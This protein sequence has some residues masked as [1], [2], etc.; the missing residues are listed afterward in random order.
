MNPSETKLR[1]LLL[2]PLPP[3]VG[4]IARWTQ[5]MT[6]S[7][8][9]NSEIAIQ[10]LDTR[11][12]PRFTRPLGLIQRFWQGI[13]GTPRLWLRLL[14]TLRVRKP[15]VVHITTSGSL[16]LMRDLVS[17][18]IIRAHHVPRILHIRYGRIPQLMETPTWET[19]LL[20]QAMGH[21]D[22]VLCLE[23]DTA[24]AISEC[25]PS[26]RVEVVPNFAPVPTL[27]SS[28]QGKQILYT[29]RIS[30]AKGIEDLI[31]AW[32]AVSAPEW[33]LALAGPLSPE[34]RERV[35]ESPNVRML[36]I[37]TPLEIGEALDRSAIYVLPSHTEGF[38]NGLLE[39][40]MHGLACISTSVGAVPHMLSEDAGIV[41]PPRS[42][43]ELSRA[44]AALQADPQLRDRLGDNA[45]QRAITLY[46]DA[47]VTKQYARIWHSLIP[48]RVQ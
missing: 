21:A 6:K 32:E 11:L 19:W 34:L 26:L 39:A 9:L 28:L 12:W 36:G 43:Q 4:G 1:V 2:S 44:L 41:V 25:N 20:C 5:L 8:H 13:L 27:A 45:R 37:L 48:R 17:L 22:I 24:A 31:T 33:E 38:P 14:Y 30:V 7:F 10:V 18:V 15:D 40:M 23:S 3:P 46:S 42:V 35:Q 16:G 29:G 47:V